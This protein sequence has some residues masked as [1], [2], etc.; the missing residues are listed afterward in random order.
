MVRFPAERPSSAP[1]QVSLGCL[2]RSTLA[3]IAK[4][5]SAVSIGNINDLFSDPGRQCA[6]REKS[7]GSTIPIEYIPF[8]AKAAGDVT[9]LIRPIKKLTIKAQA[10]ETLAPTI[11][12]S[13]SFFEHTSGWM[14][15]A[16]EARS[17]TSCAVVISE[18]CPP[19]RDELESFACKAQFGNCRLAV[20]VGRSKK[21]SQTA[22]SALVSINF[23]S[24]ARPRCMLIFTRDTDCPVAWAASSIESPSSFTS[25]MTPACAG[26]RF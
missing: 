15:F 2:K 12:A 16:S 14:G 25:L 9:K 26:F 24:R 22:I 3:A 13:A 8:S 4:T 19:A 20:T 5:S 18:T 17:A 7:A 10:N 1:A 6:L 21:R 11:T 23:D